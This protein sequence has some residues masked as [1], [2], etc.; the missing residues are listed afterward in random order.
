MH[1]FV[2][3]VSNLACVSLQSS[4][5]LGL[6]RLMKLAASLAQGREDSTS[7][8]PSCMGDYNLLLLLIRHTSWMT[9][10]G[11]YIWCCH[12]VIKYAQMQLHVFYHII[13]II[14]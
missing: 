10:H 2:M 8:H 1:N 14:I 4:D 6:R 13:N 9:A 7:E 12:I 11:I 5:H 3:N